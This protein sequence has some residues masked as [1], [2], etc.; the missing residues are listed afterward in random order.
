MVGINLDL[1]SGGR[2]INRAWPG[3]ERRVT[4][5]SGGSNQDQVVQSGKHEN[6]DTFK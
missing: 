6:M 3:R 1:T 2:E 5:S 4:V